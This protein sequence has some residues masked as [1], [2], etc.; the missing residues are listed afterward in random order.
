MKRHRILFVFLMLSVSAVAQTDRTLTRSYS[1]VRFVPGSALLQTNPATGTPFQSQGDAFIEAPAG[2]R[3]ATAYD[4]ID[5][6]NSNTY[7]YSNSTNKPDTTA[8]PRG[9]LHGSVGISVMAGLG[10]GAPKG[11]GFAQDINLDYTLPLGSRGWLTVGGYMD[12]LNWSG[13]NTTS[14]GIYG[15]LG[16]QIDDHWAAYVY[17]QKSLANSGYG[18]PYYGG[19][20][21]GFNGYGYHGYN[22]YGYPNGYWNADRLGAALRWTPSKNFMLQISVEKDWMPRQDNFYSRRYDYQR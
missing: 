6:R 11:A 5:Q 15:A 22:G 16:Y 19:Y 4:G 21:T 12:H 7:Y 18:F 1:T 8:A 17:G 2:L 14:A 3:P 10:K 20:Y 13:M 9:E